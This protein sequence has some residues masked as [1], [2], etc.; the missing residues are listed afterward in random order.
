MKVLVAV[1]SKHGATA[2]IGGWVLDAL[3]EAGLEVELRKPEDVATLDGFEAVVLGSAVYAGHWLAE[4]REFTERFRSE[5]QR[6]PVWIFSSGPVG[7]PPKP[8]DDPADA[9]P[10]LA[11]TGARE[12]RLFAGLVERQRLGLGEKAIVAALR[13][14]DGDFRSPDEVRAWAREI[15]S[16]LVVA[17][18]G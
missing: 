15:A 6:R 2:D 1:A 9:A 3:T 5:L 14:P 13:V 8:A 4:A 11:A 18:V 16:A 12:H 10:M 17:P 7:E